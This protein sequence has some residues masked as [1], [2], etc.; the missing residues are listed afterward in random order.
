MLRRIGFLSLPSTLLDDDLA[1][2]ARQCRRNNARLEIT[3]VLVHTGAF[4][5]SLLEGEEQPLA[6][7][8][9]V[10]QADARHTA[11]RPLGDEPAER[12]WYPIWSMALTE[13]ASINAAIASA[14]PEFAGAG[15]PGWSRR[16]LSLFAS[17]GIR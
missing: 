3:G 6:R 12:R 10:V 14:F 16:L 2:L 1:L 17:T 4:F 15:D 11:F 8:L 13:G 7:L 5:V 9:Q